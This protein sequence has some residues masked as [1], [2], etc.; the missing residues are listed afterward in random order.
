MNS[1][2]RRAPDIFQARNFTTGKAHNDR[3]NVQRLGHNMMVSS[4]LCQVVV[5]PA[6]FSSVRF[7]R[8]AHQITANALYT[9]TLFRLVWAMF[10]DETQLEETIMEIQ[11]GKMTRTSLNERIR[12]MKTHL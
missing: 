11:H 1:G 5:Y 9:P 10:L 7:Q 6:P 3:N 4:H 8:V 12:I 2:S